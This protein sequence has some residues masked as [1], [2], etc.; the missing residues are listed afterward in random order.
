[1]ISGTSTFSAWLNGFDNT[2][3][4][5]IIF[6]TEKCNFRC[7]YCYETFKI[8]RIQDK[9]IKG[10]KNLLLKRLPELNTLRL[11]FFGGE[12]LLHPEVIIDLMSFAIRN[13][14][15]NKRITGDITTNG[16]FLS[17][18]IAEALILHNVN[19]FQITI[20]GTQHMHNMLRP[21][22]GG[23]PTF[24]AVINNILKLLNTNIDFSLLIRFNVCDLNY[25]SVISFLNRNSW[26]GD[27]RI[28]LHFHPVFGH[29]HL[30]LSSPESKLSYLNKL[31][32]D[33]GYRIAEIQPICYAALANTFV[34]RA[35]GIVQKCTVALDNPLNCVGWLLPDGTLRLK[36]SNLRNWIFSGNP[37]CPLSALT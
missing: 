11:S 31:A 28:T 36:Q 22:A 6:V 33:K 27:H 20:D 8:G 2:Y 9:V 12:P 30:K 29:K 26:L 18:D 24:S 7:V 23:G 15:E 13:S 14:N 1:M 32:Q 16:Y 37:E 21:L 5:L 4:R 3:L 25:P 35:N 17:P 19:S 34:I 10:I